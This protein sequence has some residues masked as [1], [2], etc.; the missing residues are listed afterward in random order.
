LLRLLVI[1]VA[2]RYPWALKRPGVAFTKG[3]SRR[4]AE[5]SLTV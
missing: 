4:E 2:E 3:C 1:G 5:E